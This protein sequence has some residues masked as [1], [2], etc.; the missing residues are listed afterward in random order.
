M[1]EQRRS[2]LGSVEWVAGYNQ[3]TE[4][5]KRQDLCQSDF[6]LSAAPSQS[7]SEIDSWKG[8]LLRR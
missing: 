5:Q 6:S 7:K 2:C 8:K 4:N 3:P 1:G